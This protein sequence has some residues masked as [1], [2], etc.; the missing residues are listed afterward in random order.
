EGGVAKRDERG[1]VRQVIGGGGRLRTD[2]KQAL[3]EERDV[4]KRLRRLSELLARELEVLALGSKIQASVQSELDRTQRE[5]FLRQQLR[6]IQDEL[7]EGD[8]MAAEAEELREQLD[9]LDLPEEVRKQVD[10]H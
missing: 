8:E 10:R 9:A 2:E 4:A 1:A 6:A 5:Y 7:G 3:L